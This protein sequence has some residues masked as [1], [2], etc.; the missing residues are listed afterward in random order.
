ML[1]ARCRLTA[2][3]GNSGEKAA[4]SEAAAIAQCVAFAAH[5]NGETPLNELIREFVAVTERFGFSASACAAW[6]MIGSERATR[7]F[8]RH[9]PPDWQETYDSRGSA[10]DDVMMTEATRKMRP[11]FWD[12]AR[13]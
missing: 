12:E 9:W 5:C 6:V 1:R 3:M 4:L 7:F 2:V 10:L 8:F 11:Y 13:N